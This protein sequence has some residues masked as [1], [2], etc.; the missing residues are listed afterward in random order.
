MPEYPKPH[1]QASASSPVTERDER[2]LIGA[3]LAEHSTMTLA[4][5]SDKGPWAA[6]VFYAHDADFALYFMSSADTRHMRD[7]AAASEVAATIHDDNQGWKSLRGLQ[8]RGSCSKVGKLG[9]ARVEALYAGKFP[10]LRAAA[11][12]PSEASESTLAERFRNTPFF[13]L[14]PSWIR[15]ID[16]T[17]GFGYKTEIRLD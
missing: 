10:F 5:C 14:R 3:Y 17:R 2:R 1:L 13:Q 7:I 8:I 11:E 4:T 6:A 9:L 15:L 16:N 12:Q